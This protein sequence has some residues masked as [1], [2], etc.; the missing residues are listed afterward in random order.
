MFFRTAAPGE[1]SG[2]GGWLA[3]LIIGLILG[4]MLGAGS[5][6]SETTNM[7]TAIPGLSASSAW[8]NFKLTVWSFFAVFTAISISAGYRLLKVH[9]PK[10]VSFA[11]YSLWIAGPISALSFGLLLP[12]FVPAFS[13][14]TIVPEMLASSISSAI[15][16]GI[17]TLYLKRSVRVK[18]TYQTWV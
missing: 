13:Y 17:W 4:P 12:I 11:I 18:N 3:L 8:G 15:H 6:L 5:M 14:S 7:E 2:V 1:P 9:E 16:A 10:T